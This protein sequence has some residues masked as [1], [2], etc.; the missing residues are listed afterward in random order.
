MNPTCDQSCTMC[1]YCKHLYPRQLDGR[2]IFWCA[3]R[4][5]G[6]QESYLWRRRCKNFAPAY[7]PLTGAGEKRS[8]GREG[9]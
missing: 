6:I 7:D 2:A 9:Q 3:K 4:K 8:D 1:L 5:S